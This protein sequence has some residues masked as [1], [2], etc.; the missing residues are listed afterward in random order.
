MEDASENA[1]LLSHHRRS[2]SNEGSYGVAAVPQL[3]Q[4][5]K[6][7]HAGVTCEEREQRSH[8]GWVVDSPSAAAG[9]P[10]DIL[11]AVSADA[12]RRISHS[13]NVSAMSAAS[14]MLEENPE[15]AEHQHVPFRKSKLCGFL[16]V[17]LSSC[18]FSI[19]NLVMKLTVRQHVP[20]FQ[21]LTARGFVQLILAGILLFRKN[22]N[23]FLFESRSRQRQW[24][25][26]L[27]LCLHG[28]T[29]MLGIAG[30][31]IGLSYLSISVA[32]VLF[33]TS[34]LWTALLGFFWLGEKM[35]L[36]G[37]IALLVGVAGSV[38]CAE[39]PFIFHTPSPPGGY[40]LTGIIITNCAAFFM[41]V[42]Y[43]VV[44]KVQKSYRM[45]P[46]LSVFYNALFAA[47]VSP[48]ISL[49]AKEVSPTF[50]WKVLLLISSLGLWTFLGQLCM[51]TG[52]KYA[53][54]GS[55]ALLRNFDVVFSFI[56][57]M[58]LF[59]NLPTPPMLI[60]G[61]LVIG[62]SILLVLDRKPDATA[63][64]MSSSE[65]IAEDVEQQSERANEK[66]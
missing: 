8:V 38:F 54:A 56:F 34:L 21:A 63:L 39:P 37:I 22:T 15:D 66:M 32:T 17:A 20:T 42:S 59:H 55:A 43:I 5:G 23:P 47:V 53:P 18:I 7:A 36:F 13:R 58:A 11:G 44:R 64:R 52:F 46:Q 61:F 62:S 4:C 27:Y 29:S 9:H 30:F 16:W 28:V 49:F 14:S 12:A 10:G 24:K 1:R 25:K 45:D 26:F 57:D 48:Y 41:G 33:F 65:H 60:G 19:G 2:S 3:C 31:F 35:G 50:D 6:E 40:P 51:N